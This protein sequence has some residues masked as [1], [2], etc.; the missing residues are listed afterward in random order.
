MT[1]GKYRCYKRKV[2]LPPEPVK[3]DQIPK[4]IRSS[5][6]VN[7]KVVEKTAVQ[8]GFDKIFGRGRGI[9]MSGL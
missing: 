4:N 7:E 9:I 3:Q 1:N 5:D 8:A 2:D 6:S